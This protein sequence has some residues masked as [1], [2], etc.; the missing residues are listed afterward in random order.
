M[1]KLERLR[2][3]IV[4]KGKILV[5]FSGGVDSGLLAKVA[6]NVLG[7]NALAVTLDTV[8]LPRNELEDAKDIAYG[9]GILHKVVQFSELENVKFTKNPPDRCY[10]C[11]KESSRFLKELAAQEGIETI[12]YGVN[13]S[14][15]DEHRP[16]IV[17]CSEEGIWHPFVEVGITKSEVRA[18]AREVGLPSWDKP[19]MACLSSRIPYGDPITKEKLKMIEDAE[20]VLRTLGLHQYRVRIHGNIARIEVLQEDMEELFMLK[21]RIILSLKEIGFSYI[22]LDLEGY[23][24]GSMDEVL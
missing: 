24:S 20:G 21:E 11:K 6:Y 22:T 9:I 12:A 1:D 13:I 23:R 3:E 17:A 5:A 4:R 10:H 14:D 18:F 7:D 15:F 8:T 19:S 2:E 16:G